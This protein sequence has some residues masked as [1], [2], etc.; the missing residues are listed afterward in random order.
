[1]FLSNSSGLVITMEQAAVR[2]SV[3]WRRCARVGPDRGSQCQ[4]LP[5]T[6][7]INKEAE[8]SWGSLITWLGT[9]VGPYVKLACRG[10]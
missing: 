6:E 4:S 9:I 1:M 2:C 5:Y 10:K 3:F 7:I 8:Y